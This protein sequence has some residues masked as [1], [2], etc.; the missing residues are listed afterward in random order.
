[1][2]NWATTPGWEWCTSG[3]TLVPSGPVVCWP[4]A[5]RNAHA[6]L[7]RPSGN[8]GAQWSDA[9][10]PSKP[11]ASAAFAC[12]SISDGVNSSVA[13]ANQNWM[14][15]SGIPAA[16]P[17]AGAEERAELGQVPRAVAPG[18]RARAERQRLGGVVEHE[19]AAA[20]VPP[21]H[22]AAPP[23]LHVDRARA[24]RRARRVAAVVHDAHGRA[25]LGRHARG[26]RAQAQLEVLVEEERARVE[27]AEPA[28]EVRAR[29]EARGDRPVDAARRGRSP[30]LE[31]LTQ[32]P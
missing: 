24:E 32:S 13:A 30:G 18:E 7:R 6:E 27:R 21:H 5:P 15:V 14:S 17:T 8:H 29:G 31:P 4:A 23:G 26:A 22:R 20:E 1:M 11:A 28:Q 10:V 3:V 2:K 16:L 25:Q 19:G 9:V 12:S